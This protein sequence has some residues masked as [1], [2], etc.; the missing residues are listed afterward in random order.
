MG[1][2]NGDGWPDL[3]L[4]AP[5]EASGG[6]VYV[7]Q[8]PLGGGTPRSLEVTDADAVLSGEGAGAQAGV[9]LVGVG[10]LDADGFDDL[11]VGANLEGGA[12]AAYVIHGPLPDQL[13]LSQ[14]DAE[15]IGESDG[16]EVGWAVAAAGDVDADGLPDLLVSAPFH[17]PNRRGAV[18]LVS[19]ADVQ[20]MSLADATVKFQGDVDGGWVGWDIAG[21]ADFDGDGLADMLFGAPT[22]GAGRAYLQHGTG[23]GTAQTV[24]SLSTADVILTGASAGDE[25]G[26]AV[27]FGGDLD[28]DGMTDALVA[29]PGGRLLG[30]EV[31]L[32]YVVLSDPSVTGGVALDE[33]SAILAGQVDGDRAGNTLSSA[34][35]VDGD[36]VDDFLVGC[37]MCDQSGRV[38]LVHGPVAGQLELEAAAATRIVGGTDG[39]LLGAGLASA[40]WNGRF[41]PGGCP[42]AGDGSRPPR[43]RGR[44]LGGAS[45]RRSHSGFRP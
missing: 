26:A 20:T 45:Q 28:G 8:G 14:A 15:L 35:D 30:E 36:G 34:G 32:V 10:D 17:G 25:A 3:A 33:A 6:G 4:G 29:A 31:G 5:K 2:I 13:P 18:Y 44:A 40:D 19:A 1:D 42:A 12:G 21:N 43:R 7:F 22:A 41:A 11:L 9:S 37:V 24:K 23:S 27:A 38:Y 39:D 16:D